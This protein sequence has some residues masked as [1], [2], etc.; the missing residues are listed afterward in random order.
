MRRSGLLLRWSSTAFPPLY[1]SYL[2]WCH[3][4]ITFILNFYIFQVHGSWVQK[5][6]MKGS[7]CLVVTGQIQAT[8]ITLVKGAITK[9]SFEF[10]L[11]AIIENRHLRFC[12]YYRKLKRMT[13]VT[14]FDPS[15]SWTFYRVYSAVIFF[16]SE[17]RS[18]NENHDHGW[19]SGFRKV[20]NF[21]EDGGWIEVSHVV[22]WLIIC[23]NL[24]FWISFSKLH[25]KQHS[26]DLN[27]SFIGFK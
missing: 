8:P 17:Y 27:F 20:E 12:L 13:V 1:K 22:Y 18:N 16:L 15:T 9:W 24:C 23:V 5:L 25:N 10:I 3:N 26:P 11:M 19:S 21:L 14:L 7:I 6:E 4:I 2:N